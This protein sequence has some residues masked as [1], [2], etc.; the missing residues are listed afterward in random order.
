MCF[1][2]HN[3]F[4]QSFSLNVFFLMKVLQSRYINVLCRFEFVPLGVVRQKLINTG[5][6]LCTLLAR[7]MLALSVIWN[8]EGQSPSKLFYTK[9][10]INLLSLLLNNHKLDRNTPGILFDLIFWV[11]VVWLVEDC[12]QLALL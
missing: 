11:V 4:F 1:S 10:I 2:F 12:I 5:L 8:T 3:L 6:L 9:L 7:L